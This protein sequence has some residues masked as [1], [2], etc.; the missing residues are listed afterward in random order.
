MFKNT[1]IKILLKLN[2]NHLIYEFQ[3]SLR[4][5]YTNSA[6][7]DSSANLCY[8]VI[9]NVFCISDFLNMHIPPA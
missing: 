6:V 7:N 9:A 4:S 1:E 8:L 2:Q 3:D 5:Q